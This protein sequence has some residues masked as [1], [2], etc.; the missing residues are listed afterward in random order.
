MSLPPTHIGEM[1]M[2]EIVKKY[3]DELEPETYNMARRMQLPLCLK[4][5]ALIHRLSTCIEQQLIAAKVELP[6]LSLFKDQLLK[7]IKEWDDNGC[8]PLFQYE[9]EEE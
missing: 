8:E 6:K 5:E 2:Q 7:K 3:E 4:L 1:A 9:K